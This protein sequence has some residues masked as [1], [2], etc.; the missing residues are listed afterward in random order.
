MLSQTISWLSC[1]FVPVIRLTASKEISVAGGTDV[2]ECGSFLFNYAFLN[3]AIENS[4]HSKESTRR[5]LQ[6]TCFAKTFGGATLYN[7]FR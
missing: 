5:C 7:Y 1:D 4:L 2:V 3:C 6:N